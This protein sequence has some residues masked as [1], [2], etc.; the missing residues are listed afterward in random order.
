[1]GDLSDQRGS[2]FQDADLQGS[3]FTMVDLT[4]ST[5]GSCIVREIGAHG[6]ELAHAPRRTVHGQRADEWIAQRC[7]NGSTSQPRF[8]SPWSE[9]SRSAV[10]PAV[11]AAA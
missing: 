2:R 1:M 4:G 6:G 8:S 11:T 5:F 3:R 7:P 9:G 10:A